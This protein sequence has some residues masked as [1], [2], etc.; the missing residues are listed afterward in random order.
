MASAFNVLDGLIGAQPAT[1]QPA[2]QQIG[3][4][5]Q[6][7][8]DNHT[9]HIAENIADITRIENLV[10][11]MSQ[12]VQAIETTSTNTQQLIVDMSSRME[13]GE[14]EIRQ[15]KTSLGQITQQLKDTNIRGPIGDQIRE[16]EG[17]HNALTNN[18]DARSQ[19]LLDT[20]NL[21]RDGVEQ[22][23]DP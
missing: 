23:L 13:K 7:L 9:A 14:Q 16:A 22:H 8:S 3:R 19:L 21:L 12:K 4:M 10:S 2:L 1:T 20:I 6:S 11:T 18:L 17:K 5:L 15:G